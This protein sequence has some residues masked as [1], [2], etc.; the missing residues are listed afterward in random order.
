[1]GYFSNKLCHRDVSKVAQCSHTVSGCGTSIGTAVG[2]NIKICSSNPTLYFQLSN[3]GFTLTVYK[4][5]Q[6]ELRTFVIFSILQLT[7]NTRRLLNSTSYAARKTCL[8]L[9]HL[10]ESIINLFLLKFLPLCLFFIFIL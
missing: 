2:F 6:L 1:M 5:G 10:K 4:R 3:N 8:C 9:S 7:L